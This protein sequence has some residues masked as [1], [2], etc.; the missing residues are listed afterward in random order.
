MI[1]QNERKMKAQEE[2][3]QQMQMIIQR[4]HEEEISAPYACSRIYGLWYS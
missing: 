3:I 4:K 1:Q 2:K